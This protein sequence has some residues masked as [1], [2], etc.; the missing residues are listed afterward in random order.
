MT[1]SDRDENIKHYVKEFGTGRLTVA[2]FLE[3]HDESIDVM[4]EVEK[5]T[6][7]S[8]NELRGL[9]TLT[10]RLIFLCDELEKFTKQT[11][12]ELRDQTALLTRIA[13]AI[14]SIN[15]KTPPL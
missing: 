15:T 8:R 6:K 7:Q 2:A 12:N 1:T 10:A 3:A 4:R 5:F 11:R 13:T 14:E 9:E